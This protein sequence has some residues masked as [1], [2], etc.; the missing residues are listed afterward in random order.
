VTRDAGFG[1]RTS[2]GIGSSAI[3]FRMPF[4]PVFR[5]GKNIT[6]ATALLLAGGRAGANTTPCSV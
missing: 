1:K 3:A 6:L 5:C 2:T 4:R